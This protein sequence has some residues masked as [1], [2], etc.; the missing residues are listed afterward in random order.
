M[1]QFEHVMVLIS[2]ILGL[3]VAQILVGF[4]RILDWHASSARKLD[5]CIGHL[6]WL[7]YLLL[8]MVTFWW[9]QF[10][11]ADADW[12]WTLG[13]YLFLI[14]YSISLF[15]L[16]VILVPLSETQI[17]GFQTFFLERRRWFYGIFLLATAL[18]MGEAFVKGGWDRV[19]D[20]GPWIWG[21]WVL[22]VPICLIG[23]RSRQVRHHDVIA[24]TYLLY[25]VAVSVVDLPTLG[26]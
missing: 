8:W 24:I 13:L 5:L 23:Y 15:L 26:T 14:L 20:Q 25:N 21:L 10:R 3:G 11:I 1:D 2:V 22:A 7:V 4:G 17:A 19:V 16:A 9:W 18:D 12:V 6:V